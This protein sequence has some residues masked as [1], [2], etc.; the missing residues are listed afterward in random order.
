MTDVL[1]DLSSLAALVIVYSL[2]ID[3]FA[4]QLTHFRPERVVVDSA[5]S[6]PIESIFS[7]IGDSTSDA[8]L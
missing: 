7:V 8:T 4:Q 6:I 3:P 2:A 1:R 5:A